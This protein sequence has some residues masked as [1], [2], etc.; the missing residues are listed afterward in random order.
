MPAQPGGMVKQFRD[1]FLNPAFELPLN[2]II[3]TK[4]IVQQTNTTYGPY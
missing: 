4:G 2:F 1:Y 3:V